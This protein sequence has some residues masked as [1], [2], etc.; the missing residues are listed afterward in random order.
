MIQ[1]FFFYLCTRTGIKDL[2]PVNGS[3]EEKF[4]QNSFS[5]DDAGEDGYIALRISRANHSCCPNAC[6]NYDEKARVE[7]LFSQREIQAGEEICISY[8]SFANINSQRMFAMLSPENEFRMIKTQLK[9]RGVE[10]SANCF[11]NDPNIRS[12][13]IK[14]RK[15]NIDVDRLADYQ[16]P[17]AALQVVKELLEIQ[18]TIHSSLIS[19]AN[20]HYTAFQVAV[21]SSKT[22]PQASKHIQFVHDVYSSICPYSADTLEYERE[23]KNMKLAVN[24]LTMG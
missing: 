2:V 11:C 17:A 7:I 14:G 8:L 3:F 21:M 12:L 16:R 23:M 6:H 1:H 18:E 5:G 4:T 20:T 24:Y 15:L 10:C 19:K 22:L 13:V 9:L